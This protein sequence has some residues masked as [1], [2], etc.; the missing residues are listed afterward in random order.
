MNRNINK[1]PNILQSVQED[2]FNGLKQ[3][4]IIIKLIQKEES[5][6]SFEENYCTNCDRSC[7]RTNVEIYNCIMDKKK[8]HNTN[9]NLNSK[10]S[11]SKETLE[12]DLHVLKKSLE[13]CQL[14]ISKA[15]KKL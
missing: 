5:I 14:N 9:E 10:H 6:D 3:L 8:Q 2:I 4:D 11:Y 1:I 15:I 13:I 7:G 12:K